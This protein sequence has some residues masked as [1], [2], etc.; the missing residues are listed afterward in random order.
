MKGRREIGGRKLCLREAPILAG[1]PQD[2]LA[3]H[4][5]GRM[6]RR[7]AG[8]VLFWTSSGGGARSRAFYRRVPAYC[9]EDLPCLSRVLDLSNSMDTDLNTDISS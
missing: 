5:D 9:V 1:K 2:R 4:W 6:S 7:R 8:S 3:M